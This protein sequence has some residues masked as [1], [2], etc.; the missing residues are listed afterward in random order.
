MYKSLQQ[1]MEASTS[2]TDKLAV[3]H[4]TNTELPRQQH[5]PSGGKPW[6]F[7]NS[8]DE[9]GALGLPHEEMIHGRSSRFA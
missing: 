1:T 8:L 5:R 9:E 2:N 3:D 4:P 6:H 7:V